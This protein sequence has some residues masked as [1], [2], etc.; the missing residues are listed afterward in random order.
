MSTPALLGIDV[1]DVSW[2]VDGVSIVSGVTFSVRAGEFVALMGRNGAGKSTVL[3]ILAGLRDAHAGEVRVSGR[4]LHAW[5]AGDRAR[6]IAH[7]PQA[8]RPDLPF[9]AGEV[10]LMGR[11]PHTDR[12]LES[13]T[14]REAVEQAMRRTDCWD[15]R[16]RP[17]RTLS[18]G[19]RQRVL[20][21]AC[22]AQQPRVWLLDEPSTYLDI[23]Q[24]VQCFTALRDECE[25]GALCVAVTHDVNLALAY[26]TRLVV[27][28]R[29]QVAVDL[30]V[31]EAIRTSSWLA[32]FSPRLELTTTASGRPWVA[33]R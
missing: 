22:F 14:D 20:L 4:P 1:D 19:E 31:H 7:L 15:V 21:A 29:G 23:D 17:V 26:A 33:Y 27:L 6:V 32:H 11:Y 18:G 2:G 28:E 3:D 25:R 12:C 9:T 24:Q 30:A 16:E 13:Q 5:T 10:V 8:V